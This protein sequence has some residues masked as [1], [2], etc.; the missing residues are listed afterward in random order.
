[1]T[2]A[3]RRFARLLGQG[4]VLSVGRRPR[5]RLELAGFGAFALAFLLAT[6][7]YALHDSLLSPKPREFM[8]YAPWMHAG[9]A[10]AL[11]LAAWIAAR[12][13]RRAE[14]WLTLAALAAI[15]SIP[16]LPFDLLVFRVLPDLDTT[17][18]RVAPWVLDGLLVLVALRL[19]WVLGAGASASR[20]LVAGVVFAALLALPWRIRTDAS[21]WYSYEG[22]DDEE[23]ADEAPVAYEDQPE[24]VLGRQAAMVAARLDRLAPQVPGVVDLYAVGFAGDGG[25]GVFRNEVEY[26]ERL[27]PQRF[28]ARDRVL[29]LINSPGTTDTVPLATLTN[30]RA[31]LAG[32]GA[33]ID[34]DEDLVLLF[35][36]SHGSADHELY[37]DLDPLPLRQVTP[38]DLRR[39]LDDAG[40]RW[41]VVVVSA[42]YS[43]GFIDELRTPETLVITAA[44]TDR[45]SFG[46][47]STSQITYFGKAF[48][49]EALNRTT[50]FREAYALAAQRIGEW[51]R[52]DKRTPSE[53]QLWAGD[54]IDAKLAQWRAGL[55]PGEPVAFAPAVAKEGA[56]SR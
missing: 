44:R 1:V 41:R 45:T 12:V 47:G 17:F 24:V 13:L 49:T 19:A 3:A 5:S 52:A 26:L 14:A 8:D 21:F 43:G 25:E 7:A 27:L 55:A 9:V 30:L 34:R 15:A 54:R 48:L 16:W 33:R 50:D 22:Q 20:R 37:V 28:G 40:I 11:L 46:C 4:L 31:A 6:G 36:T 32:I 23:V 51:E 35:L 38:G 18:A 2:G 42:C 39:A 53:P 56:A 29:P 10:A